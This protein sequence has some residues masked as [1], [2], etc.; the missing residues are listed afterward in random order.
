MM[1]D[2]NDVVKDLKQATGYFHDS[3]TIKRRSIIVSKRSGT[4][5]YLFEQCN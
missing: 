3:K 2:L 5:F 4:P 1:N